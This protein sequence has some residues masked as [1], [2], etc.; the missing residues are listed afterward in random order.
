MQ[1]GQCALVPSPGTGPWQCQWCQLDPQG[2]LIPWQEAPSSG[3]ESCWSPRLVTQVAENPARLSLDCP[4]VIHSCC[5]KSS[6]RSWGKKSKQ[7]K[8]PP[9]RPWSSGKEG[10][11]WEGKSGIIQI[12]FHPTGAARRRQ[13]GVRDFSEGWGS[14]EGRCSSL[15]WSRAGHWYLLALAPCAPG[16][17]HSLHCPVVRRSSAALFL[18]GSL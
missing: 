12:F 4:F 7:Q 1:L 8:A 3:A 14:L 15:G 13:G 18:P 5:W 17:V 11:S 6:A 2:I 16:I 10:P 9:E